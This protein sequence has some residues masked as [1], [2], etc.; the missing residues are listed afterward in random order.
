MNVSGGT[1][2]VARTSTVDVAFSGSSVVGTYDLI[3][4]FRRDGHRQHPLRPDVVTSRSAP[5]APT[6]Y[7]Y[8][9][10]SNTAGSQIDLTVT[11]TSVQ[12]TG[13]NATN[14]TYWDIGT[15]NNWSVGAYPASPATYSDGDLSRS[16]TRALSAAAW[17]P[18]AILPATA[19]RIPPPWPRCRCRVAWR[20]SSA[21][22]ITFTNTGPANGGVDYLITAAS[23]S[24]GITGGTG[25][26]LAGNGTV[27]GTV[28]LAAANTFSGNVN[29]NVGELV[30]ENAAALGA[31][32]A[33]NVVSNAAL[34]LQSG[35]GVSSSYG[36]SASGYTTTLAGAGLSSNGALVSIN[37]IN[38]YSGAITIASGGA[39]IGS[40][41]AANGDGLTL[42]G[43]IN[44]GSD[45]VTFAGAGPI[46]VSNTGISGGG[47]LTYSGT[48][49]LT[50]AVA[51][52]YSGNTA[53]NSGTLRV[54]NASGSATG[55]GGTV[56]ISGGATLAGSGTIG[57]A[58]SV[59]PS[60]IVA[61]SLGTGSAVNTLTIG[62][63][64]SLSTG[65]VLSYNLSSSNSSGN[66]LVNV[67][68]LNLSGGGTLN[69]NPIN[70]SLQTSNSTY[71]DLISYSDSETG[72]TGTW[73]L[74]G[75]SGYNYSLLLTPNIGGPGGQLDL[76]VTVAATSF[77]WVSTT[78][79][80]YE[81]PT[82]W[83]PAANPSGAGNTVTF[84][85][86]ATNPGL[87]VTVGANN[88]A[89]IMTFTSSNNATAYTLSSGSLTLNNNGGSNGLVGNGAGNGA[90]INVTNGASATI[91]TPLTLADP[92]GITTFY[93][94]GPSGSMLTVN[95][96]IG[97]SSQAIVLAGGGI[98]ELD[99][100]NTYSGGT[101]INSGILNVA[102]GADISSG[103]Q[104]GNLGTGPLTINAQGTA[105]SPVT[106]TVNLG[107]GMTIYSLSGTVSGSGSMATLNV[108]NSAVTLVQSATGN[109][110]G[111]VN[112][113]SGGSLRVQGGSL[114]TIGGL[115]NVG[116]S[117]GGTG[118]DNDGREH[119]AHAQRR[120]HAVQQQLAHR[121]HRRHRQHRHAGRTWARHI[122]QQRLEHQC[123]HRQRGHA[124]AQQQHQQSD[125]AE[126]HQRR[127]NGR[128]RPRRHAS[129]G[130]QRLG[131]IEFRWQ[132]CG[133]YHDG[134]H[135][136]QQRRCCFAQRRDDANRRHN[137]QQ[138]RRPDPRF[139][140]R[141][142]HGLL[143]QHHGRRR[144]ERRQSHGH[145][146]LAKLAHDQ[147]QCDG[148]DP[149]V[150]LRRDN[151]RVAGRL[152][153][154]GR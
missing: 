136:H 126:H 113:G 43:G 17:F 146:D 24:Y 117:L 122:R 127:C 34:G 39:T 69:I 5:P 154:R 101:T 89:G 118:A 116:T 149:A 147:R 12:W 73:S 49:T 54:T 2:N 130:R 33:V 143:R 123:R 41:S 7:T 134:R 140:R 153:R 75:P 74:I 37:G 94:D 95:A 96:P 128:G 80:D 105:N 51:S 97:G 29:V 52:S 83:T 81:S 50:L 135:R 125:D 106:S 9:L 145:A 58:V 79:G 152:H 56:A 42:I 25:I 67:A 71:Y 40:L 108:G 64:L 139:Q 114:L 21:T 102:A 10:V 137:L 76:S 44:T 31:T 150:R 45:T 4:I 119:R 124:A 100:N 26:T 138:H 1:L 141:P 112:I 115:V 3:G 53:V 60:G 107:A 121:R 6:G 8:S 15:T 14:P 104:D 48:S 88:V 144:H 103:M 72:L 78:S 11:V 16:A 20:P 98:L 111:T 133:Q 91:S 120:D 30:L 59:A 65:A 35:S 19:R 18:R 66:D 93:V 99:G 47:G 70:G 57:G 87:V 28:F 82:N 22:P 63:T 13:G 90:L 68:D 142:C 23:P 38:T 129:I 148:D 77:T 46:T 61:P 92:S 36:S 109:F 27:G 86:T 131:A 151:E 62:N 85:T 110:G 32:P 84:P 55:S 132:Q